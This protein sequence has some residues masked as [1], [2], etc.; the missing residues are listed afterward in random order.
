[1]LNHGRIAEQG[2]HDAADGD[3]R[4][5]LP[6]AVPAAADRRIGAAREPAAPCSHWPPA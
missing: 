3:R 6:A 5:H 4:R 2:T 1:M